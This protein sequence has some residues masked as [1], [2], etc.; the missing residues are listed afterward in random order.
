M[1]ARE[2]SIEEA[3]ASLARGNAY[4]A[5]RLWAWYAATRATMLAL[6]LGIEDVVL[7]DPVKWLV[8][9]DAAGPGGGLR[10]YP[11]PAAALLDLPLEIGIPTLSH[12]F[13]VVVSTLVAV[14]AGMTWTLWRAAGR[15]FGNGLWLWLLGV[16]AVGP[17]AFAR[18]DLLPAVLTALALL[19]VRTRAAG[20][21]LLAALAAALKI[22]PAVAL[23]AL[24][25]PGDR[26]ARTR[27]LAAFLACASAFVL[28]TLVAAGWE[29]LWSPF[30]M[31]GARGLQ[32]E[33]FAALPL[34]WARY[35]EGG[36]LWVVRFAPC[37]CHEIF[38]PGVHLA[39]QL[40]TLAGLAGAG[41]VVAVY[42]RAL[43]AP[44][45]ERTTSRAT[46][47]AALSVLLWMTASK[48]FS[49]QY[50]LWLAAPLAVLGV[51]PDA[52]MKRADV[53][54]FVSAAALTHL[55]YPLTYEALAVERHLLQLVPLV[56]LSVRDVLLLALAWRL[57]RR[58]WNW[59]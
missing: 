34:L 37:H 52:R 42:V 46:A 5:W 18:Y 7:S 17:I 13:G 55:V 8:D 11:W 27:L 33:A 21:G 54:L 56:A 50:L 32:I 25:L 22:W 53:A 23:P 19:A 12:Y 28:L 41:L 6:L 3:G 31:Q 40:G 36:A 14:D 57:G 35:F 4:P 29:R 49:V 39:L 38:G 43:R 51:L 26:E 59:A 45:A 47:V 9:L 2:P 24:L 44:A 48:V 30:G 1:G 16:A 15:R 20:A 10:E 58:C